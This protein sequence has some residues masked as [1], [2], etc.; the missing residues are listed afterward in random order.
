[1]I[2][3]PNLETCCLCFNLA[4]GSLLIGIV[5]LLHSVICALGSGYCLRVLN[6]DFDVNEKMD[7]SLPEGW[8]KIEKLV[9]AY[10]AFNCV[11]CIFHLVLILGVQKDRFALIK[12]WLIYMAMVIVVVVLMVAFYH[13]VL[14]N[15]LTATVHDTVLLAVLGYWWTVVFVYRREAMLL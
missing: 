10:M 6:T 9:I 7:K 3:D 5:L 14:M 4:D 11:S 8:P 1:M 2:V 13:I 15:S 12:A